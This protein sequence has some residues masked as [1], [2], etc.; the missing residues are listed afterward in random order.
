MEP[1]A[2][3]GAYD[4]LVLRLRQV[5]IAARD[6]DS[7]VDRL[8]TELQLAVCFNDPGVATF[9]LRNALMTVGDQFIEVVSPIEANT[10]AGRLLDRRGA[11]VSA[12]MV[13][14]EVD[15]LDARMAAADAAGIRTVWSGDHDEIRGRHLHPADI[16]GAIVSLDQPTPAGSWMWGGP[17]WRAHHDNAMVTGIAGYTIAVDDPAKVAARW[18]DLGLRHGVRFVGGT[19]SEIEL[20]SADRNTVGPKLSLDQVDVRLV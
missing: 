3:R 1:I 6:L 17:D 5:V 19:R 15:D 4:A 7:V 10:A 9:G 14:F 8:C 12:Y 2:G 16:G 20:V 13:M 11:D 18:G